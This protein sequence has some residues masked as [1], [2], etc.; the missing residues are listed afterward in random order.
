MLTFVDVRLR[1]RLPEPLQ[2]NV[3]APLDGHIL[4]VGVGRQVVIG[5]VLVAVVVVVVER[6]RRASGLRELP[7]ERVGRVLADRWRLLAEQ[8]VEDA[9]PLVVV[10]GGADE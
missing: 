4:L 3:A 7:V 1:R 6:T 8:P 5:A 9:A 10:V 2:G